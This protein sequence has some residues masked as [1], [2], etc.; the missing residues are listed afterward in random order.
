MAARFAIASLAFVAAAA[1]I[2]V[3][4][5]EWESAPGSLFVAWLA[6]HFAYGALV[7]SFSALPTALLVPVVIA[8]TPWEGDDETALWVQA[9]FA[10]VFYGIPFVFIGVIARRLWQA[11]R[12]RELSRPHGGEDPSR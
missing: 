11:R 9:A 10:E 7:P 6:V 2:F 8:P 4:G 3:L 1:A 5:G 12:P